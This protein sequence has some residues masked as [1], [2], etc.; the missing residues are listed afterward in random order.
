MAGLRQPRAMD[1]LE[2]LRQRFQ[3]PLVFKHQVLLGLNFYP[4]VSFRQIVELADLDAGDVIEAALA[5]EI[6][7]DAVGHFAFLPWH[8]ADVGNEFFPEFGN[9]FNGLL[10]K[11]SAKPCN[12]QEVSVLDAW[13]G[14]FDACLLIHDSTPALKSG[15]G[16][17]YRGQ[18]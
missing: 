16:W 12:Q 8:F 2:G 13:L 3:R 15:F 7:A 5:V 4:A 11:C 1:V 14:H 9:A 18:T 17:E 10:G 6:A